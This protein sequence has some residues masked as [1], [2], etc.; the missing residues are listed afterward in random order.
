MSGDPL[1]DVRDALRQLELDAQENPPPEGPVRPMADWLLA[2]PGTPEARDFENR[3]FRMGRNDVPIP[4]LEAFISLII[5]REL[6]RDFLLDVWTA[7]EYPESCLERAGWL[8]LFE[9]A[10][11][12]TDRDEPLKMPLKA[13][14]GAPLDDPK[15]FSW[16]WNRAIATR[17][18]ERRQLSLGRPCGIFSITVR[19][20]EDLLGVADYGGGRKE[21]ELI[22]NPAIL[23]GE[24]EPALE[25]TVEPQ[26]AAA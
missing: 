10:G 16:T 1:S 4:F 22:I 11:F 25:E 5:S 21:Q 18:A 23:C 17:F 2:Q 26:G 12:V 19:R 3:L 6:M 20:Q 8:L 7:A 15:G 9:G 24:L 14:R 13:F